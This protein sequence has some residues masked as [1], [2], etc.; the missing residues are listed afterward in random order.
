MADQV[1]VAQADQTGVRPVRRPHPLANRN[2]RLLWM[3]E[4]VS[5][6]GDQFYL[7]ALPFLVFQLT[8]SSLAFGMILMVEGVPRA[9]LMLVGGVITDRLSPRSVMVGSN[10]FRLVITLL[11]TLLVA[12]QTVQLWMLFIIALSFGTVDA[13]F[14]PAY[15]ATIPMIVDEDSLQ[16]SNSLMQGAS[17]LVQMLGPGIAGVLVHSVGVVLSFAFDTFTFAFTSVMLYMMRPFTSSR[18]KGSSEFE[19]KRSGVLAEIG[20]MLAFVKRNSALRTF[21]LIIAAAN[22][23]LS[24]PLV[25]GTATLGRIRFVEGSAAFGAMLSVFSVGMLVGTVGA[26]VVRSKQTGLIALLLLASQGLCLIGVGYTPTLIAACGLFVLIGFS[27]GFG[28]VYVITVT[29]RLVTKDMLGRFMSLIA[30]AEVGLTPIS[31]AI[32]GIMAESNVTG[33]FVL[34]GS[35]M[36]LT[37]LLAAKNIRSIEL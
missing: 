3:G 35:L 30:L 5:L 28:N 32:A 7:V 1:K 11:L 25:V 34:A 6:L 23:L 29:Q 20:D 13:F 16:S 4:N 27:A 22:L 37:A 14:H 12:G 17:Q 10:L 24:G 33:L 26:G 31:N 19:Q 15:R 8:G 36:S 21:V 2:F 9:A 18:P